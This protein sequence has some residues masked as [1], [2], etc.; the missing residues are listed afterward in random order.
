M[1]Y[2]LGGITK[3]QGLPVSRVV[4]IHDRATG[5]FLGTITSTVGT[6]AWNFNTLVNN[7][8]VYVVV[9]D[10]GSGDSYNAIIF[11]K[12]VPVIV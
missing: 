10:D 5:A 1:A 6:G 8:Q 3:E 4:N 12:I 9:L 2:Q 7:N 11:D